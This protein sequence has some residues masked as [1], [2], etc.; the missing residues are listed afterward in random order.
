MALL[1]EG[2]AE[3]FWSKVDPSAGPDGCWLWTA[4]RDGDG[5]GKIQINRRAHG[6][7]RIAWMFTHGLIPPGRIVC[8]R[9]DNPPCVNPAHLFI[10]TVAGNNRDA[11]RK[12][13]KP[14]RRGEQHPMVKLTATDVREIRRRYVR[15]VVGYKRLAPDYGI[16]P[17]AVEKIVKGLTWTYS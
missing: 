17:G 7:H 6:A 14:G 4:F 3:R 16:T 1:T 2:I 15:G 13:R 5:Y 12:G 8:H 10:T 11:A 9:C